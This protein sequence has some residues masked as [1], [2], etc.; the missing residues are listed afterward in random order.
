MKLRGRALALAALLAAPAACGGDDA[1][2]G[3]FPGDATA[4]TTDGAPED[5]AP[6]RWT[7]APSNLPADVLAAGG[8]GALVLDAAACPGGATLDTERGTVTGC[9]GIVAGEHFRFLE[10]AQE[11]GSR[12]GVFVTRALLIEAGVVV[13]VAGQRPLVLVAAETASI[14]GTLTAAGRGARGVAG[15]ASARAEGKGDGSGP[16]AGA[17][18]APG[19]AGGGGHCGRGG[20]G[21]PDRDGVRRNPGGTPHGGPRLVPLPGSERRQRRP[22][23]MRAVPAAVRSSSS[24]ASA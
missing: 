23:G 17:G 4:A 5:G 14:A 2:T 7:F 8:P 15:G 22:R 13:A 3:T 1:R 6:A 21:G 9:A 18:A 24:P 12:A 19:G 16:G 10:V 20:G 11:D